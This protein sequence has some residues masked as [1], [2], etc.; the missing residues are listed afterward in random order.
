MKILAVSSP[1]GHWV[2]LIRL[3]KEFENR[4]NVVYAVPFSLFKPESEANTYSI[5]DVSADDKWRLIPCALKVFY[6]LLRERPD[7]VVSTGAAPGA[8]AVWLAN[9]LGIRTIW[10]DSIANVRE[11]SRAG[12]LIKNHV[13]VFLTQWADLSD[14][15]KVLFRGSVL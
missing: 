6:I 5:S 11:I 9:H 14:G 3:T 1:G 12:G 2:Q 10:I 15:E 4:H 8:V 13:D 7:A